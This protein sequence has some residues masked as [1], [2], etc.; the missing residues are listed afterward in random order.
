MRE[1][2]RWGRV[3]VAEKWESSEC[4]ASRGM[5][6]A[7]QKEGVGVQAMRL[8]SALSG[9]APAWLVNVTS[10]LGLPRIHSTTEVSRPQR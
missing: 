3:G 1:C 2:R 10:A 7:G 5:D 6:D 4:S 9:A 8:V